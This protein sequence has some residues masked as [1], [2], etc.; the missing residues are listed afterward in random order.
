MLFI[1]FMIAGCGING[2]NSTNSEKQTKGT[3]QSLDQSSAK[4]NLNSNKDIVLVDVRTPEEF[5]E[6]RIANSILIP[7]YDIAKLA[8]RLLPDQE[9]I[10]YVYC[11]S[12]RRSKAAATTLVDMG[13]THVYDI[14]G[15]VDWKYDT[16]SGKAE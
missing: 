7:D 11:R 9:A 10:I 13:Y 8:P 2:T 3:Y 4:E 14:G 5:E 1:V 15:I 12:G 16:I 6:Q